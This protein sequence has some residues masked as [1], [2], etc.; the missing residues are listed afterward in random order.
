[1]KL[2]EALARR[3]DVQR[4]IEQM[5]ARLRQSA[6]VQEG[7]EPTEDPEALLEEAQQLVGEL[8]ELVRRINRTNLGATLADGATTLTDALA[9]RDALAVR[10]GLLGSVTKAAS[11]RITR[12]GR[13]EIRILPT[14]E[15]SSLRRRMDELARE[16]RELDVAIQR[17]NWT[18]ELLE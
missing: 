3:A 8:E 5:R 10:H 17:A 18:V 1:M 6:L 7:E 12:Y 9:R 2:A 15:V 14:V 13:N 16:R 4:H 11:E